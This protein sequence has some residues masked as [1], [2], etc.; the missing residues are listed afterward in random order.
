MKDLFKEEEKL[1][2][3][4]DQL[5][6]EIKNR[7]D[8]IELCK[9]LREREDFLK[10]NPDYYDNKKKKRIQEK[11]KE[12]Y[13]KYTKDQLNFKALQLKEEMDCI[14]EARKMFDRDYQN[15]SQ[16]SYIDTHSKHCNKINWYDKNYK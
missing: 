4:I 5:N 14:V 16:E 7:K 10:D 15:E 6:F 8:K 1:E 12:Y 2:R 13:S 11:I 3:E 9:K